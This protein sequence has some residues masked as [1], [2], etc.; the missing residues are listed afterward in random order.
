MISIEDRITIARPA[1]DVFAFIAD[2]N[3]IPTW[4]SEVVTSKVV[5]PGPTRVGTR[6]TED[7]KM[8]PRRTT[9]NCEVTE[10]APGSMMGF[11][12]TSPAMDYQGRFTLAPASGGSEFTMTGT[13]Q[14]KGWWRLMQPLMEGEFKRGIR[15]ELEA[16]KAYLEGNRDAER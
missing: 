8:G 14:L 4:Q 16:V 2:L 15:K 5:T 7:V 9:A 13:A 3:N 11:T 10:F 12:A 6:F 1:E